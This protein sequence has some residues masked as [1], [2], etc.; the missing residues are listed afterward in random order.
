MPAFSWRF[1]MAETTSVLPLDRI[2]DSD[3]VKADLRNQ[4]RLESER[5]PWESTWR[6]IDERFPDGAGGFNK[7]SPGEIRGQR[8]FDVTHITANERFAAAGVAIT[9]PLE[10]DY[11]RPR[12]DRRQL[13]KI[14]SVQLWCSNARARLH[15]IRHAITPGS[16]SRRMRI[17]T[18]SA[19]MALRRCGRKRAGRPR[20]VL[21]H[22]APV[23]MLDRRRLRRD[24]RHG[25]P[26]VHGLDGA[27]ARAAV[28]HATGSRPRCASALGRQRQ[29]KHRIR[30]P[31]LRRCRTAVGRRG[32]STGAGGSDREPLSGARRKALLRRGGYRTRCRSAS[33]PHDLSGREIR[34]LA[35]DQDDAQHRRRNAMKHTTLRAGTRRSIRRCCSTTTTGRPSWSTKPGGLNPGWS[36]TRAGC[37]CTGCPAASGHPYARSK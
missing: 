29:G 20:A 26:Q 19:A 22:A 16:A 1:P 23:G 6:E 36:T 17:G 35:G 2:Q 34:P 3:L 28:R 13:M 18:S 21:P 15:A 7:G 27:P 9:T 24:G 30:D 25:A 37:W 14:R 11:I 4:S 8:N 33:A 31:A 32:A 5:A 12:F 10:Q